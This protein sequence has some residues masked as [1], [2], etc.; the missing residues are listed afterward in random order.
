MFEI[1]RKQR[2][3]AI[4][5]EQLNP[6][7]GGKIPETAF[8]SDRLLLNRL[9]AEGIAIP[10]GI[11]L[12]QRH[13]KVYPY[14]HRATRP[15]YKVKLESFGGYLPTPY[16]DSTYV[17]KPAWYGAPKLYPPFKPIPV[18]FKLPGT[19]GLKPKVLPSREFQFES[20]FFN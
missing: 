8:N 12:E 11:V 15:T 17:V 19:Q 3:R 2:K 10:D 13:N 7:H 18:Y 4:F 6:E 20:R 9:Q 1:K 5:R 16:A 14:D